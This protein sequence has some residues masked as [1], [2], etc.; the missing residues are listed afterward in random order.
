[1]TDGRGVAAGHQEAALGV[2]GQKILT[3]RFSVPSPDNSEKPMREPTQ[4]LMLFNA[5]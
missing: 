4:A 2:S 1:M 3:G 5:S